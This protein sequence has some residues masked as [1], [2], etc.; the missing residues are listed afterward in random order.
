MDSLTPANFSD[1][2]RREALERSM[3]DHPE[4]F[5]NSQ[6]DDAGMAILSMTALRNLKRITLLAEVETARIIHFLA[7]NNLW[8]HYPG[9]D[10]YNDLYDMLAD[11]LELDASERTFFRFLHEQLFPMLEELDPE[12]QT[13]GN[14]TNIRRMA[15][16]LRQFT[17][18]KQTQ[19]PSAKV[20]EAAQKLRLE[21][22]DSLEKEGL[23]TNEKAINDR[24]MLLTLEK[25]RDAPSTN[26]L[27]NE[28]YGDNGITVLYPQVHR[29]QDVDTITGELE[30]HYTVVFANLTREELERLVRT[31]RSIASIPQGD[32]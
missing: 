8:T 11:N 7:Q 24:A 17:G 14:L 12:H 23:E 16:L 32:W 28:I 10:G 4:H 31:V 29:H 19:K 27:V 22:K 18:T 26:A 2:I 9:A 25:T 3:A 20:Q 21:A 1:Q 6:I 13:L 5:L 15:S 30:E